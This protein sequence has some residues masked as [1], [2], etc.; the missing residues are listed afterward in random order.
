M[1]RLWDD[2]AVYA[3]WLEVELAAAESM[4]SRG[5][6]PA[7]VMEQLRSFVPPDPDRIAEIERRTHHDVIAFLE[8][9]E[10]QVGPAARYLHLGMTSS[11]VL[12]TAL[13]LRCVARA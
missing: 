13:A 11:D 4:A 9:I 5:V 1:G 12:D 2:A 7:A 3:S 6:V 8:A 10:E